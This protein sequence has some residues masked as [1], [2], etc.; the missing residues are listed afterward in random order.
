FIWTGSPSPLFSFNTNLARKEDFTAL[1]DLLDPKWKGKIVSRDPTSAG[2]G[3]NTAYFYVHH[4]LGKEFLRHLYTEQDVTIIDDARQ[5]AESLALGKYSV[6]FLQSGTD[7][8]DLH[9]QGL[10]VQDHY[11]PFNEG[12]RISSGSSLSIFNHAA[13]PNAAKLFINWWLSKEGQMVVQKADPEDQSLRSDIPNDDIKPQN[14][15]QP[16]VEYSFIDAQAEIVSSEGEMLT[17]RKQVLGGYPRSQ[18]G[19]TRTV[20]TTTAAAPPRAF[21]V[22]RVRLDGIVMPIIILVLGFY[23]LYPL[24][25]I[26][27]N[28]FNVARIAEPARY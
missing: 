28:S 11:G 10:P 3:Q 2:T 17:F 7:V 1:R 21:P 14:R 5:A 19:A 13:H 8:H 18:P 20:Q 25:L 23:V 27:V 6:Y 4:D 15:R 22:G 12:A 9:E 16:D 26:L 24:A